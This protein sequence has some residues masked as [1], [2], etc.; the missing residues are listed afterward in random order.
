MFIKFGKVLILNE[1]LQK[2]NNVQELPKKNNGLFAF[3]SLAWCLSLGWL[4]EMLFFG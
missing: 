4:V 3:S 1:M 2:E